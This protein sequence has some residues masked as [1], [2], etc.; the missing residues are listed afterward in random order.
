[1]DKFSFSSNPR[2][3]APQRKLYKEPVE[4][5]KTT[6]ANLMFDAR[7]R[8]GNT[9]SAGLATSGEQSSQTASRALTS[10][11]P[12]KPKKVTSIFDLRPGEKQKEDVDLSIFLEEQADVTLGR[13]VSAQTDAFVELPADAP[14]VPRKSGID[15]C[16][17]MEPETD[18]LFD[19]DVEVEPIL[20]V[21]VG[22]ILEQS[23]IELEQE[24]EM[25]TL[26]AKMASLHSA[27]SM[28][29]DA[30]KKQE[31]AELGRARDR[32]IIMEQRREFLSRQRQ[33]V[34]KLAAS[35]LGAELAGSMID[36]ALDF[37][38][39]QGMFSDPVRDAIELSF[40]P[41]L[42]DRVK[43]QLSHL[44]VAQLCVDDLIRFGIQR[45]DEL[46]QE[47]RRLEAEALE[48]ERKKREEEEKKK[49]MRIFVRLTL[50]AEGIE[51]M[52]GPVVV[53]R[54]DTIG[55]AE[56]AI[57]QWLI[58][59]PRD[60]T[61]SLMDG[62]AS[63]LR[64]CINGEPL[65]KGRSLWQCVNSGSALELLP[66]DHSASDGDGEEEEEEE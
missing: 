12:S 37:C 66:I 32:R 41:N 45:S 59:N 29:A 14:Y 52:I 57:Q 43:K 49:F 1:M 4:P 36:D 65:D 47:R 3:V 28:E 20:D 21:M 5:E 22:K 24:L 13:G 63:K 48:A 6:P 44:E 56:T 25:K 60:D 31:A 18:G 15:A 10:K 58:D 53:R 35:Q 55:A 27:K 46:T 40:M 34:Q 9:Y 19:F 42:Y 11:I 62:R 2:A 51:T 7:V 23:L 26:A 50:E 30:V 8:R 33:V 54:D 61:V 64:L 39:D 17:Q 38:E 16:T